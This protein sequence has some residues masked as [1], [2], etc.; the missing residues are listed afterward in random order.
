MATIQLNRD[1][2]ASNCVRAL[3]SVTEALTEIIGKENDAINADALESVA[4]LQAEKARLAAS[5]ARS[6]QSVAANRVAFFSVEQDLLEELKVH[7]QSFEASVAEQ[8]ALLN[9][10]EI[11]DC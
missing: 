10:R 11:K 9:D 5:H 7:T 4:S 2:D 3:I 1:F 8:H 6:T